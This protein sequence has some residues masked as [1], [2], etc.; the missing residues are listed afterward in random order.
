ML[1]PAAEPRLKSN[2]ES[3]GIDRRAQHLLPD[4][5]DL[6]QVRAFCGLQIARFRH[7]PERDRQ[8]MAGL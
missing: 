1:P 5:D 4:H 8:Q 3:V 7:S 2:V 6:H